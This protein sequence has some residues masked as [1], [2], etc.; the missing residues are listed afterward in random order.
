MDI[1][2]DEENCAVRWS[3]NGTDWHWADTDALIHIYEEK[4]GV[5]WRQKEEGREER[6][7]GM[8]IGLEYDGYADGNPVYD[9]W[10]CSNCNYEW[11]GEE[12]TLPNYCPDCGAE[13]GY[14]FS[15]ETTTTKVGLKC[16]S[17][18]HTDGN[19]YTSSPPQV[20][21]T[22]TDKFHYYNDDCDVELYTY[23]VGSLNEQE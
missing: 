1:R 9:L 21:C 18:P 3:Y 20:K 6:P 2:Y 7:V 23:S 11:D 10:Q 16:G 5:N 17:C 19:C 12:D 4:I 22:L 14:V 8:W 13:M 15:E